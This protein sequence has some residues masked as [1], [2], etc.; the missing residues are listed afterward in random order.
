MFVIYFKQHGQKNTRNKLIDY[1]KKKNIGFG[2]HYRAINDLKFY[3][4]KYKWNKNTAP[5]A[6]DIGS[7][8]ISLPLQPDLTEKEQKYILD[9]LK[10]FFSNL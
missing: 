9:K 2:I 4:E 5:N 3:K 7:N 8:I 1:L 6:F 10:I